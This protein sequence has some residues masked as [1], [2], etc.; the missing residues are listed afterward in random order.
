MKGPRPI[1]NLEKM[2]SS[3]YG[4]FWKK[5]E[6]FEI[7]AGSPGSMVEGIGT[8]HGDDTELSNVVTWEKSSKS[9]GRSRATA[10]RMP[11]NEC[12]NE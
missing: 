10:K 1:Y 9:V 8:G 7:A 2:I 12:P 11:K 5:I 6:N 4:V 3:L